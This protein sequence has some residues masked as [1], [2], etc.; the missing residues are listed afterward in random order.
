MEVPTFHGAESAVLAFLSKGAAI[1]VDDSGQAQPLD[2]YHGPTP[3][4]FITMT[5]SHTQ[6]LAEL[7]A[8]GRRKGGLAPGTR[9]ALI[10]PDHMEYLGD[11]ML[12]VLESGKAKTT[13]QGRILQLNQLMSDEDGSGKQGADAEPGLFASLLP[14][15][16]ELVGL[17][18]G[19]IGKVALGAF[20]CSKP[21][22][23][24]RVCG[25]HGGYIIHLYAFAALTESKDG[26]YKDCTDFVL[27]KGTKDKA[28]KF[29]NRF[30]LPSLSGVL[31]EKGHVLAGDCCAVRGMMI[32]V[33]GK[34]ACHLGDGGSGSGTGSESRPV[35]SDDHA[36][37][38]KG[39]AT[40]RGGSNTV[41]HPI[42]DMAVSEAKLRQFGEQQSLSA[43]QLYIVASTLAASARERALSGTLAMLAVFGKHFGGP[44]SV[45][46]RYMA[47][48]LGQIEAS[49]SSLFDID[50]QRLRRRIAALD[51]HLGSSRQEALNAVVDELRASG[52]VVHIQY[53][54]FQNKA[55][56]V[57]K[58]TTKM[59]VAEK[60]KAEKERSRRERKKGG[61][62]K[63]ESGRAALAEKREKRAAEKKAKVRLD[64]EGVPVGMKPVLVQ[65]FQMFWASQTQIEMLKLYGHRGVINMDGTHNSNEQRYELMTLMVIDGE[66]RGI[67]AAH[68]LLQT[69]N[70]LRMTEFLRWCVAQCGTLDPEAITIDVSPTEEA[71]IVEV[72]DDETVRQCKFHI[73]QNAQKH[74]RKGSAAYK[75]VDA[76]VSTTDK[77]QLQARFEAVSNLMVDM[78]LPRTK[79]MRE[80]GLGG[81]DVGKDQEEGMEGGGMGVIDISV[82]AAGSTDDA[83]A[84]ASTS[85][86]TS[87]SI[88]GGSACEMAPTPATPGRE[89]PGAAPGAGRGG[90]DAVGGAVVTVEDSTGSWATT[91]AVREGEE[92]EE[93]MRDEDAVIDELLELMEQQVGLEVGDAI[94]CDDAGFGKFLDELRAE[95]VCTRLKDLRKLL[96]GQKG[97]YRSRSRWA[98]AH[99]RFLIHYTTNNH[100]ESYHGTLKIARMIGAA[101]VRLHAVVRAI[102]AADKVI[103]EGAHRRVEEA[104]G[105]SKAV[106]KAW[107]KVVR[108]GLVK[109]IAAVEAERFPDRSLMFEKV[110]P[111][112]VGWKLKMRGPRAFEWGLLGACIVMGSTERHL[113]SLMISMAT[114]REELEATDVYA[115]ETV[116]PENP[117]SGEWMVKGVY[118]VKLGEHAGGRMCTCPA[119]AGLGYICKHVLYVLS[120]VVSDC[121]GGSRSSGGAASRALSTIKTVLDLIPAEYFTPQTLINHAHDSLVLQE[122]TN[123]WRALLSGHQ[124]A[125]FSPMEGVQ[126]SD[127]NQASTSSPASASVVESAS[128]EQ[129]G[130]PTVVHGSPKKTGGRSEARLEHVLSSPAS[131]TSR[132]SQ[133]AEQ[134]AAD[135]A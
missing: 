118:R 61:G 92:E 31:R 121:G 63:E 76:L 93:G 124:N 88:T 47:T 50:D 27:E 120:Q 37:T 96:F 87:T 112:K 68:G 97:M 58:K 3:D 51:A 4:D 16:S 41:L 131:A 116:A 123:K 113:Q 30:G 125:S 62:K 114:L 57:R 1:K 21:G 53:A 126:A 78:G 98:L 130:E 34:H 94:S 105:Y 42:V 128:G 49:K 135:E 73:L 29:R 107:E 48:R 134:R 66:G 10:H 111:R 85:L 90:V 39:T 101:V 9:V 109:A 59:A 28:K 77:E 127:W 13:R 80:K 7:A 74:V 71:A 55:T 36:A 18:R 119:F 14:P 70:E 20:T 79:M 24:K 52:H 132:L 23:D 122:K 110:A 60:E 100:L 17:D 108:V 40:R 84:G 19:K 22:C 129:R 8:R 91:D 65:P 38:G 35:G 67:P 95:G 69:S 115:E 2:D 56:R 75:I 5:D 43:H 26:H 102:V 6:E 106:A 133:R 86:S 25:Y 83:L 45:D 81:K 32:V 64:A 99:W 46:G 72:F 15:I 82:A 89:A 12:V 104:V 54:M 117:E 11:T 44:S 103:L 33:S